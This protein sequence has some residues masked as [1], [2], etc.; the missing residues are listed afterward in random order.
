MDKSG[1]L[2][3]SCMSTVGMHIPNMLQR[4]VNIYIL[5]AVLIVLSV[6]LMSFAVF[7]LASSEFSLLRS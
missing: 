1:C 7:V 5:P 4:C 6:K 3:I 2:V